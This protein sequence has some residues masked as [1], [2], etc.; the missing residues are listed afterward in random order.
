M[1]LSRRTSAF[2]VAFGVWSWV[3]W[4]T[5]LRNF[6]KDPRSWDDGPTGFFTV[7]LVLVAVSLAFGTVIGVLGVRGLRAGRP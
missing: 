6:W 7:H 1:K 2:L 5:F 4:P 3:I